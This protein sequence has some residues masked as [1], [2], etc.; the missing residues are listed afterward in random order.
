M[1]A[2]KFIFCL[3]FSI[4][5]NLA[6]STTYK[7]KSYDGGYHLATNN[8]NMTIEGPQGFLWI[9]TTEG[10]HKFDGTT[11]TI[12]KSVKDDS[13]T[14]SSNRILDLK[15]SKNGMLWI[16]TENGLNKFNPTT[17]IFTRFMSNIKLKNSLPD[18]Y[19]SS[20]AIDSKDNIWLATKKGLVK[21]DPLSQQYVLYTR[22]KNSLTSNEL[23]VI[24]IDNNDNIW[25][26]SEFDG[27]N[28]LN[29]KTKKI[30]QFTTVNSDIQ[31]GQ[32]STLLID[33]NNN[34]WI[35]YLDAGISKIEQKTLKIKN[36]TN[37]N[38]GIEKSILSL[39]EDNKSNI[40]I[41]YKGSGVSI[42]SPKEKKIIYSLKHN[43]SDP[44]GLT[45]NT[46]RDIY[47]DSSNNIWLSTHTGGVFLL[48]SLHT[49][50]NDMRSG[51]NHW[52]E[53]S[54]NNVWAIKEDSNN[55]LWISTDEKLHAIDFKN[56]ENKF[57]K[58]IPKVLSI[59]ERNNKDLWL[60]STDGIFAFDKKEQE[61]YRP[62]KY[63]KI[64]QGVTTLTLFEDSLSQIWIGTYGQGLFKYNEKLK[65]IEQYQSNTKTPS[66][67]TS[68]VEDNEKTLWL[69]TNKGLLNINLVNSQLSKHLFK[70]ENIWSLFHDKSNDSLLVGTLNSGLITYNIKNKKQKILNENSGL[71]GDSIFCILT[72]NKNLWL[73]TN[74]GLSKITPEG[75]IDNFYSTHGLQDGHNY[76]SCELSKSGQVF[77]GGGTGASYFYPND[78][79]QDT[80]KPKVIINEMYRYNNINNQ[81]E[82][83]QLSHKSN[84]L[85]SDQNN[86]K[87]EF[88]GIYFSE[89]TS[90]KFE[91]KLLGYNDNWISPFAKKT[92]EKGDKQNNRAANYT[93]LAPGEYKFQVRARYRDNPWSDIASTSFSIL[94]PWWQTYLA[95]FL[96][97]ILIILSIFLFIKRRTNNLIKQKRELENRVK[98]RTIELEKQ[99]Q[100]SKKLSE[101]KNLIFSNVSHEFRTPLTIIKATTEE[102]EKI[103]PYTK[104]YIDVITGNTSR[105][106]RLVDNLLSFSSIDYDNKKSLKV[107]DLQKVILNTFSLFQY[108]LKQH[109]IEVEI[110]CPKNTYVQVE[111]DALDN[112][113]IN[114]IS[115]AIKYGAS[116][117]KIE[118][119]VIS[120]NSNFKVSII[121]YGVGIPA[122]EHNNVFKR[123]HRI[124]KP[125]VDSYQGTGIG[126]ALV[127]DIIE[128]NNGKISIDSSH[129]NG[130]KFDICIPKYN[131]EP[132]SSQTHNFNDSDLKFLEYELSSSSV[133]LTNTENGKNITSKSVL[134]IDDNSE[135]QKLIKEFLQN[136]F[137]CYSAINGHEGIKIAKVE[138]PDI[139]ICDV[140]MPEMNGFEVLSNIKNT[141]ETSHIP[142]IMLTALTDEQ[143][144]IKGW[145]ELADDYIT[146]PFSRLSLLE[147]IK[148]IIS[149]RELLKNNLGKQITDPEFQENSLNLLNLKDREFI[150]TFEELIE[151]HYQ[152]PNLNRSFIADK[153]IISERQLNRKLSSICNHNFSEYLRKFR[154]RKSITLLNKGLQVAQISDSVGFSSPAYFSSCFKTEFGVTFKQYENSYQ[155]E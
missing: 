82:S 110:Q 36:I 57:Y 27:L 93:N 31:S 108:L 2:L 135:I 46:V 17:E 80:I 8:V 34:L 66:T 115:N 47:Q 35:G 70:T 87:F 15:F 30:Q 107:F 97:V 154:L 106:L 42:Y 59:I 112:I 143:S 10:L 133:S 128:I 92:L 4:Y 147:R 116:G 45:S 77:F 67:I 137:R 69:G 43:K 146:K 76:N 102:I 131:D 94:T 44:Y 109:S 85:N 123:F 68:I 21:L 149:N 72:E 29:S 53:L 23:R 138:S 84:L 64:K 1:K 99:T 71:S 20:L 38:I 19:I 145:Q 142:I 52:T 141:Q 129:K 148:N 78:I 151:S 48:K 152:S 90:L 130:A 25:V 136:Q 126:L 40:W 86:I 56:K 6:L 58:N 3:F 98:E 5:A 13:S 54:N 155:T 119:I 114:L 150:E 95:I 74:N 88:T 144:T 24:K 60:T 104:K 12:Y 81:Y 134:I 18:N 100:K 41:G 124:N 105:L 37:K 7:F 118:C 32:I 122:S 79:K 11:S 33:K 9:A 120:N 125:T 103:A 61:F 121:D 153:L 50:S 96:Y 139:I 22:E 62:Y 111:E 16:A 75:V 14:I 49:S 51:T 101:E 28:F 39:Y 117:A 73:A 63:S 26:A 132:Q 91:Y 65:T 127:K 89:P 83:L 140:M 113:L 55:K